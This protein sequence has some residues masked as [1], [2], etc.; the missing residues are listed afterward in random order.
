VG[1]HPASPIIGGVADWKWS[2]QSHTWVVSKFGKKFWKKFGVCRFYILSLAGGWVCSNRAYVV[3]Y[4]SIG[5][6]FHNIA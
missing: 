6:I 3:L 4:I 2:N 1:E 5:K